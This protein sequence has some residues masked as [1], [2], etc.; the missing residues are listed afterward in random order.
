MSY[1]NLDAVVGIDFEVNV[2]EVFAL[3]GPNGAGKTTTVEILEG[4]RLRTGGQVSVLGYD[5]GNARAGWRSQYQLANPHN[6]S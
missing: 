2:G 3:L 1:G 5:P 4:F 6:F